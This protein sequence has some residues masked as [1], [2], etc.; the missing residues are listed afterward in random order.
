M[1]L[2]KC[3]SKSSSR[4]SKRI[5]RWLSH[6]HRMQNK[7]STRLDFYLKSSLKIL[8]WAY[9]YN[10]WSSSLRNSRK[11]MK[12]IFWIRFVCN[13]ILLLVIISRAWPPA[14]SRN[15]KSLKPPNLYSGFDRLAKRLEMKSRKSDWLE[16]IFAI[17]NSR[18]KRITSSC[19]ASSTNRHTQ[20]DSKSSI[21][22][23]KWPKVIPKTTSTAMKYRQTNMTEWPS[24]WVKM[25]WTYSN[26][27]W[28]FNQEDRPK[29]RWPRNHHN[30]WISFKRV[31]FSNYLRWTILILACR[32]WT[33]LFHPERATE[34]MHMGLPVSME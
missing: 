32:Q 15:W 30:F 5:Y 21:A 23:S 9:I 33:V 20:K 24:T 3:I 34:Q 2:M 16:F 19:A 4:F 8:N 31:W 12:E 10:C 29:L 25:S 27:K 7:W 13:R 17:I 6:N 28:T 26:L 14:A 22:F 11:E 18:R 1:K